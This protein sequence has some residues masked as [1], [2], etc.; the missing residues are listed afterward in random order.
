MLVNIDTKAPNFNFMLKGQQYA[1]THQ[2][3]VNAILPSKG[4]DHRRVISKGNMFFNRDRWTARTL[5]SELCKWAKENPGCCPTKIEIREWVTTANA[6]QVNDPHIVIA[7]TPDHLPLPTALALTGG[8]YHEAFHTLYSRRTILDVDEVA[9]II[10]PRWPLVPDWSRYHGLLQTWNNVVE[11]IRIERLGCVKFPGIRAKMGELQNFILKM[12]EAGQ[13]AAKAHGHKVPASA[14]GVVM[15]TYRDVGLGY[16]TPRQRMALTAYQAEN[17]LA[18]KLVTEGPIAPLLREAISLDR[19]DDLG[20]IRLAFD[21]VAILVAMG[22]AQQQND[23]DEDGDADGE[24]GDKAP[25]ITCPQCDAPGHKLIVRPKAGETDVGVMTC[26]ECGHQVDVNLSTTKQGPQGKA[27]KGPKFEGFKPQLGEGKGEGEG[28]GEGKGEGDEDGDGS[29]GDP[30][31]GDEGHGDSSLDGNASGGVDGGEGGGAGGSGSVPDYGSTELFDQLAAAV[32]E[33]AA[34]GGDTGMLDSSTALGEAMGVANDAEDDVDKSKGERAWRPYDPTKDEVRM[35]QPSRT[36]HGDMGKD[37]DRKRADDLIRAIMPQCRYLRSRLRT[38]IKA[39]EQTDTIHGL[40]RG[41]TLSPRYLVDSRVSLMAGVMPNRAYQETDAKYD[42][43]TAVAVILDESSSMSNIREE[44]AMAMLAIVEPMDRLGCATLVAGVRDGNYGGRYYNDA[45]DEGGVEDAHRSSSVI[46]DVFKGWSERFQSVKWRFAN[47]MAVSSTPLSDGMQ[48]GLE[49][50]NHRNEGHRIM[51]VLTD[52]YPNGG[53]IPVMN[54]QFR[55]AQA[56]GV[57][58]IGVGI[59]RGAEYVTT[60]FPDA[61]W[62]PDITQLPKM[63]IKK[64]NK[65]LDPRAI[66]RGR[67]MKLQR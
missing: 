66:K 33:Q 5:V 16:S 34:K 20:C 65:M 18:F 29:G 4:A 8:A 12:E 31:E 61:I 47:T 37:R 55:R 64:L 60:T 22:D 7:Q 15:K 44:T 6:T 9:A 24:G 3:S 25:E 57:H 67:R 23:D 62:A 42:T 50:L 27:P 1:L 53:H 54:W 38:I 63:L 26:T 17:L 13:E 35:I 28:E 56:A 36:S 48:Y 32:L 19:H 11:D 58:V 40:R 30:T 49:A 39:A 10:I 2:A 41:Q 21:V 43:S 45:P 51:F 46:I 59:G 52:G 14:L